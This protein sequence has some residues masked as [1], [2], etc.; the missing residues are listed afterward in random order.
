M[1]KTVK[2]LPFAVLIPTLLAIS[3]TKVVKV[4]AADT[5]YTS[6]ALPTTINLNDYSDAEVRNYY[7]SLNAKSA[8]EK[9]GSNLLKNLKTILKQ[10]QKYY[11]YDQGDLV[12]K[13]YEITDRDWV[14]SPASDLGSKYDA[15]TNTITGYTYKASTGEDANNPFVKSY[16]MDYTQENQVRAWGNHSQDGYG[17]NRE[18]LWPK[19]E[20]FDDDSSGSGARGDPMHLVAANGWA[21]NQHNNN[22]YGYVDTTKDYVDTNTKYSTVGHNL[23][24]ESKTAPVSGIKVFEPQD[25]DKGDIARAMFYM[26]AR[27][28]NLA[29][30]DT[31]IGGAN[32]NLALTDDLSKWASSGYTSTATSCGYMAMMSDLLE[33]N[34]LDPVDEYEIHR[35]NLLQR[36]F[37]NNR[38]P[39]I[40]FPQW[41]DIIWG[42]DSTKVANP[43][44]DKMNG[45][46]PNTIS[47]FVADDIQFANLS[48]FAP[49]A[50]AVTGDVSFSYSRN[51]KGPFVDT[52][53]TDAGIWYIKATSIANDDYSSQSEIKSFR[54]IGT[55]NA[56]SDF[57]VSDVD[58][59]NPVK[60]SASAVTGIVTFSYSTS[61]TGPFTDEV[62]TKAGTYYVKATSVNQ[63]EYESVSEIKSFKIIQK[64]FGLEPM[65]FYIIAGAVALVILLIILIVYVNGSKK[66]KKKIQKGAKKVAKSLGIPVPKTTS[67]SSSSS[68]KKSSSSSKKS[69]STSKSKSTTKKSTTTKKNG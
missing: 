15:A 5:L 65:T 54:I 43:N 7:S 52:V 31:T 12:W 2:L 11:N 46:D 42:A 61:Q 69:T 58:S 16:Y 63:G 18:H 27:Y 53:P 62:P 35:N 41:A 67:T 20:G 30:D 51:E 3:A 1:K 49:S 10:D 64:I 50:T 66:S 9:K 60:P 21:N 32:P 25:A 28:N 37:T 40:D 24:G 8:D 22:F 38:N 36:N 4:S 45:V 29:A 34:K 19:S 56:I 47:N 13:L 33:W 6:A 48:T 44:S 59:G 39:F 23:L 14:K 26:V 68:T 57:V 55:P 17:I